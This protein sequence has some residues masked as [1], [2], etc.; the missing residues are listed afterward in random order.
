VR[1]ALLDAELRHIFSMAV[2]MEYAWVE[3][4]F[5]VPDTQ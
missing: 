5:D 2:G 3:V 4:V 1:V